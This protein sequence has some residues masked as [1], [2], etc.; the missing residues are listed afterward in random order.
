M[1]ADDADADAAFSTQPEAAPP[2]ED[3]PLKEVA[4]AKENAAATAAAAVA[5]GGGLGAGG[6]GEGG[7]GGGAGGAA[8][9]AAAGAGEASE[10]YSMEEEDAS[11]DGLIVNSVGALL[12]V[13][14]GL[15]DSACQVRSCLPCH[16][17]C[18]RPL[19][20]ELHRIT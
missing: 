5:G 17:P 18:C 15:T 1:D 6:G 12:A 13:K 14:V 4:P 11:I 8:A 2:K 7:G 16:H 20:L 9:G 3:A 19:F 10:Y